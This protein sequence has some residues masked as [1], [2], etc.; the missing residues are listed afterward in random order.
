MRPTRALLA[1]ILLSAALAC[2]GGSSSA[3][4]TGIPTTPSP[5]QPISLDGRYGGTI[6][7]PSTTL[8]ADL[9]IDSS[10]KNTEFTLTTPY[11]GRPDD[12]LSCIQEKAIT[13]TPSAGTNGCYVTPQQ[14]QVAQLLK[15]CFVTPTRVEGTF[16]TFPGYYDTFP[17]C[18]GPYSFVLTRK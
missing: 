8:A 15:F 16:Q 12:A 6:Q 13:L 11:P 7:G 9:T 14:D 1:S 18:R 10:G 17:V 2:G 4:R 3:D 5:P